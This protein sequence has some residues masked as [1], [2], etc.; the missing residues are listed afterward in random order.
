MSSISKLWA[1]SNSTN[2]R[3][4]Q[5][6]DV[7]QPQ[8]AALNF[9]RRNF[10]DKI[11]KPQYEPIYAPSAG[12]PRDYDS[13]IAE[14]EYRLERENVIAQ[15]LGQVE[16]SESYG[17]FVMNFEVRDKIMKNL[18]AIIRE[19]QQVFVGETDASKITQIFKLF[20]DMSFVYNEY[21]KD[22]AR[23][24]NFK[25][26]FH[27][28]VIQMESLFVKMRGRFDSWTLRD[29]IAYNSY[30]K[31]NVYNSDYIADIIKQL[32]TVCNYM[33]EGK[34][35]TLFLAND[36]NEVLQNINIGQVELQ[37][38]L[39]RDV[40]RDDPVPLT[41]DDFGGPPPSATPPAT[42]PAGSSMDIYR[43]P[44]G[45][46]V[47]DRRVGFGSRDA[48]TS[49]DAETGLGAAEGTAVAD[50]A[51]RAEDTRLLDPD[52]DRFA[53]SEKIRFNDGLP[54]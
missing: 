17:D 5:L 13:K 47:Y 14:T 25:R 28:K 7:T 32:I 18:N 39:D 16:S 8:A 33:L 4:R 22:I 40:V 54:I 48:D 23:D 43:T 12:L 50:A 46:A 2:L 31:S 52:R 24:S 11:M 38:D 3:K 49:R 41:S 20:N 44:A 27:A 35:T 30:K 19:Q 1:I 29:D 42:P 21:L 6:Q 15:K 10:V 45:R 26:E 51:P 53:L 37:P 9:A 36:N 34:D